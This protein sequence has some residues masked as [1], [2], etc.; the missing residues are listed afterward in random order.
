MPIFEFEGQECG[1][2][3]QMLSWSE[4]EIKMIRDGRLSPLCERCDCATKRIVSA[5]NFKVGG[6]YTAANG[7]STVKG[8]ETNVKAN[9]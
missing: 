2:Q 4:A 3:L 8:D 5:C 1:R 6:N 9:S 7:Y